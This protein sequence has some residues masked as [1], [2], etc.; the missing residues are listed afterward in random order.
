MYS[1][2]SERFFQIIDTYATMLCHTYIVHVPV[3]SGPTKVSWLSVSL[4][5]SV[6]EISNPL[7]SSFDSLKEHF[8]KP[9]NGNKETL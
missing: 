2:Q 3:I 1:I 5:F 6:L 7:I 4:F 9:L 8:L